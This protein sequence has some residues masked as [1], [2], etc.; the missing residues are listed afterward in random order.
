MLTCKTPGIVEYSQQQGIL[1]EAYGP[2]GPI[3]QGRPGP[4]DKVLSKL[5]EKYKR[6]E[7]QILLRWVL[8][9][10]ILPITTTSKEERI[11]DVL[12]IFDFELDKEDEDQ[13]TKVGKEKT[14]RQFSKEYSKYD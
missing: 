3:T 7:G 11:N 14:L 8:Q 10:G 9:R 4:L 6:N 2:L 12:E 5:S 13:I 1:I